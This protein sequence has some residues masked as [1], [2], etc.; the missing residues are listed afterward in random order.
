[1]FDVVRKFSAGT[2]RRS[3][4]GPSIRLGCICIVSSA[5]AHTDGV[6]RK[7]AGQNG[8]LTSLPDKSL[9]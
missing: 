9:P 6:Y 1:M 7:G 5:P 4:A 2:E 8:T 3:G